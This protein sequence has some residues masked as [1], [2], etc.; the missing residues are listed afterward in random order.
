MNRPDILCIGALHWDVIG[1]RD[2]A[3]GRGEDVPG[4]VTRRPGGV[5]FNLARHLAGHGLHPA[6]ISVVGRD[7]AGAALLDACAGL[8]IATAHVLRTAAPTGAYVAIE[9]ADGLV[10]AIADARGLEAAGRAL[11]APLE[12]GPLASA[13]RPWTGLVAIDGN[14]TEAVLADIAATPA[15]AGADLRVASASPGK[16]VRLRALLG[17]A[18]PTAFY[19]NR[20]EAERLAGRPF[21]SAC[22]AA[23]GLRAAGATQ[24]LVTD[25]GLPAALAGP[26]GTLVQPPLRVPARQVTGAG[27]ALMAAHVAAE[28]RGLA[29]AE[30][31]A[32]ALSA[33]AAHIGKHAE[34]P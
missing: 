9:D 21:P 26:S 6:L 16:A 10:A 7:A 13:A 19:L 5:A 30:A 4:A 11:L 17:R 20:A 14:L 24:A 8:G 3:L 15:L 27:D 33:A 31:L 29:P 32:E 25:G 18:G 23:A 1:R 28:R 34:A 22:G 12:G 2:G